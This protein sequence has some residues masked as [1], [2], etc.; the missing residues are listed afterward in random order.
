MTLG[1]VL[2]KV[3]LNNNVELTLIAICNGFIEE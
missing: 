1:P 3:K 2:E